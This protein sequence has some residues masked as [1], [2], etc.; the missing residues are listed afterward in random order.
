MADKT[1]EQTA[2]LASPSGRTEV[3]VQIEDDGALVITVVRD[4]HTVHNFSDNYE[5]AGPDGDPKHG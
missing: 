3:H 5:Q 1:K 2:D 4:G